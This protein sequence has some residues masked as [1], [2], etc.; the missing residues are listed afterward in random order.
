VQESLDLRLPQKLEAFRAE[1]HQQVRHTGIQPQD[2]AKLL[3]H[4]IGPI[5]ES[6]N[7]ASQASLTEALMS[8][9]TKLVQALDSKFSHDLRQTRVDLEGQLVALKRVDAYS[10]VVPPI[11]DKDLATTAG[12]TGQPKKA[13]IKKGFLTGAF[14]PL[15][16]NSGSKEGARPGD[17]QDRGP[18]EGAPDCMDSLSALTPP[19]W[20]ATAGAACPS[21]S[22]SPR[23]ATASAPASRPSRSATASATTTTSKA[24]AIAP[25]A[26]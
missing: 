20:D 8:K 21:T 26:P 1:L 16:G 10:P 22:R 17:C 24:E 4:S 11:V 6:A 12:A 18:C 19:S 7:N 2:I 5:A 13:T 9:L 15:Y 23:C 14:T 25:A 3:E